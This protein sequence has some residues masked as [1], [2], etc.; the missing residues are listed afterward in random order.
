MTSRITDIEADLKDPNTRHIF[1]DEICIAS[2]SASD[3]ARLGFEVGQAWAREDS[4][5][6]EQLREDQKAR[7]I[8]LQLLSRRAW[9]KKEMENRLIKRG[10]ES[11]T[12]VI[13]AEELEQDGWLDDLA[14]AGA[15]IRAW[16]RVEP[17]SRLWLHLKL[18]DK[19]ISESDSTTAIKEELGDMSEQQAAIKLAQIRIAR[20][21]TLDKTTQRRRVI[22]ALQR[23]GFSA[24][25]A[26]EAFRQAT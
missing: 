26:S 7:S 4:E 6:I 11:N 1:V 20:V 16:L 19:G 18:R 9:S 5:N 3:L 12:A 23:R 25:V 13:V 17:A 2:I 24:D 14:Y 21:S 8:A 10:C 22:G 15:C